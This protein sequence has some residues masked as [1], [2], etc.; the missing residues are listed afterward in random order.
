MHWLVEIQ[1]HHRERTTDRGWR[2]LELVLLLEQPEAC[3]SSNC[4]QRQHVRQVGSVALAELFTSETWA[5]VCGADGH[6][7]VELPHSG[8]V[9]DEAAACTFGRCGSRVA[10][11][12]H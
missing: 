8:V 1:Q 9:A 10:P 2:H 4:L 11:V 6:V 7:V 3:S 5:R 12:P